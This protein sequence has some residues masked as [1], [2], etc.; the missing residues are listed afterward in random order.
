MIPE[1]RFGVAHGKLLSKELEKIKI[2]FKDHKFDVLVSSAIIENGI[3]LPNANTLIVNN[4]ER[5]GLA[6]LYQLRGRVGRGAQQSMC[7][8][9]YGEN[10]STIARRRLEILRES[11]DGFFIAEEDLKLRGGGELMGTKQAGLPRY[12]FANFNCDDPRARKLQQE[13]LRLANKAAH[14]IIDEYPD[15]KGCPQAENLIMLM[16]LFDKEEAIKYRRTG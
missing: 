1:A 15:L 13:L 14:E 16:R 4:A 6:Q 11:N 3:D 2:D 10:V 5:F 9:L 8:L 12:R 7:I